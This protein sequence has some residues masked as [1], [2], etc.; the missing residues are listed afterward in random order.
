MVGALFCIS[1]ELRAP[2]GKKDGAVRNFLLSL[3]VRIPI[4]LLLLL[5]K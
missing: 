5:G 2:H 4:Y 1:I 3:C